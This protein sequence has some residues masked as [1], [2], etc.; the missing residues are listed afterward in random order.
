MKQKKEYYKAWYAKNKD[1]VR[2]YGKKYKKENEE[3]VKK[4]HRLYWEENKEKIRDYKKEWRRKNAKKIL[5]QSKSYY[6][7]N[8]E[9]IKKKVIDYYWENTEKISKS[10]RRKHL[11]NNCKEC[12]IAIWDTSTYC[13]P[14]RSKGERNHRWLDGKSLEPYG[15]DFNRQFKK[16]I[17]ERENKCCI[18]C[19][20]HEEELGKRLAIHHIDY[21]K[22]NTFPQNCVGLCVPCHTKTNLNRTH[23]KT[24]FQSLL[25]ERYSYGYTQD[26]KII[27]D[28]TKGNT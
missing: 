11:T 18:I 22:T 1:R 6:Q 16:L 2:E 20:K 7:K 9:E 24:F 13:E 21:D 26:Q 19:N 3:K 17:R 15:L 27:L 5:E 12:R 28:F 14:C 4:Y 23:W 10:H 8:K 25:K